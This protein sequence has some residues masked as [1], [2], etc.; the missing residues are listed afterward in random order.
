VT[1]PGAIAGPPTPSVVIRPADGAT[2]AVVLVLPGGRARSY[3]PSESRHLTVLRMRPFAAMLHRRGRRHG[4]EVRQLRYRYRGWND[5]ERSPVADVRWALEQVR[6][7]HGDVPVALVGHS[8]GGRTA[9]AVGGDPGVRGVCA[10]APWVVD[11]DPINQ[12]AGTPVL[13][14]HGTLDRVTSPRASRQRAAQLAAIG[15]TVGYL[16]VRGDV[17]AMVFRWRLWN[18]VTVGFTLGVLDIAPMPPWIGRLLQCGATEAGRL[19]A[20]D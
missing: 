12:L 13:I 6:A 8:M 18:R 17:H 4:L 2:A 16:P 7:A 1:E 20:G 19:A 14:A 9:F 11:N 10:L 15:A 5:P 3:A